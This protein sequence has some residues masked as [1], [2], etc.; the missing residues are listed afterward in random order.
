MAPRTRYAMVVTSAVVGA[1]VVAFS[2]G[3]AL[4]QQDLTDGAGSTALDRLS[5]ASTTDVEA[6]EDLAADQAR[7]ATVGRAA[8]SQVRT[9]APAPKFMAEWVR[10]ATGPLSSVYGARWGT[11]HYGLDIASAYGSPIMAASGGTVEFSGWNG[12]Y[13]KLVIINHGNGITT[14]Y[15]HNST[16]LVEVGDK[17]E[18]GEKIALTGSTG[19][20]TGAH[21][22]FEVRRGE[23]AVNPLPFMESRGVNMNASGVDTSR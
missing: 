1:G 6:A 10:P 9:G 8:R 3:S 14:R 23:D 22:H 13:G 18:A 19:Y 16:L 15:G 4:P 5:T 20:S 12:G 21:C 2:A 7:S 11:T 17:V